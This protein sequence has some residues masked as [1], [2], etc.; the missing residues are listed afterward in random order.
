[1]SIFD[2]HFSITDM[3]TTEIKKK[4]ISRITKTDDTDLLN[5]IYSMMKHESKKEMLILSERQL[6]AIEKAE[7]QISSGDFLTDA[8]VRK[9]TGQWLEPHRR[10]IDI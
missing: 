7:N 1:M 10:Y 4:L 6:A 9:R 2:S 8:E 3:T 5:G